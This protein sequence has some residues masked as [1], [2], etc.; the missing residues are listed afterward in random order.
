MTVLVDSPSVRVERAQNAGQH[1]LS[2]LQHVYVEKGTLDDWHALSELHYKGHSLASGSRAYRA[3]YDD[4]ERRQ[5]IGVCIFCNPMPLNRG[6]NKVFPNMRPNRQ[7]RDTKLMNQARMAD[8]NASLTWNNRTVLDT[9]YRSA[10]LAYRFKNLAYRMYCA[11]EGKRVVESN[12]SMGRF[13]PFSIKAGMRMV[14]PDA[15]THQ[16]LGIDFFLMNF[17][18]HPCDQTA[19][20]EELRAMPPA[21]RGVLERRLRTFYYKNSAMEKSG[22]LRD[23]GMARVNGL[24]I[25]KVVKELV[26]IVFSSTIYWFWANPDP[27]GVTFPDRVPVLAF[28]NQQPTEPFNFSALKRMQRD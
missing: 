6:R 18:A 10:G 16:E 17:R 28:D 13:N 21:E 8:I 14:I 2:L 27:I 9:A 20:L 4:G 19:L 23:V 15:P 1:V 22:D 7:G 25:E 26:Q 5:L 3:V 11:R 12:S 24:P